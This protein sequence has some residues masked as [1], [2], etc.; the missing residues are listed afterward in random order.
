MKAIIMR[1]LSSGAYGVSI[2]NLPLVGIVF[3]H[4]SC[5]P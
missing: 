2:E 4:L 3:I 5:W 1:A